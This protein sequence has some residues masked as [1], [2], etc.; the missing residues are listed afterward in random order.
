MG[1]R[2]EKKKKKKKRTATFSCITS[3]FSTLKFPFLFI[4]RSCARSRARIL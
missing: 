1:R 4:L 3:C 2:D